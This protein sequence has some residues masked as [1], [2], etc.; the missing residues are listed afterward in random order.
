M[1][2]DSVDE[3]GLL[4][5]RWEHTL[6]PHCMPGETAANDRLDEFLEER[7]SDY[8]RAR[9]VP[10]LPATSGLSPHLRWGEISPRTVWWRA[11]EA[12]GTGTSRAA[13]ADVGGFL[14]ELGWREFAWHTLFHC[15]ALDSTGLDRRYDSFPWRSDDE[16]SLIHI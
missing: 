8:D 16:L 5:A 3:W 12:D 13:T 14:S 4:D 6:E 11:L 10:S 7:V 9:D 2:S 15:G 1:P